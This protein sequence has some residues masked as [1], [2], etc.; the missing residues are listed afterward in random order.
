MNQ[1]KIVGKVESMKGYPTA[2]DEA[3]GHG[4]SPRRRPVMSGDVRACP[5]NVRR[6]FRRSQTS[7]SQSS[8]KASEETLQGN[9]SML[10]CWHGVGS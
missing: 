9:D 5:E 3:Q 7:Y 2:D 10:V 6:M 8:P 4:Q 1:K